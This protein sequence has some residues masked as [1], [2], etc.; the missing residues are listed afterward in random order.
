[1]TIARAREPIRVRVEFGSGCNRDAARLILREI[2]LEHGPSAVDG[3]IHELDLEM[4][5]GLKPGTDF[6]G[7]A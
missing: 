6:D 2:Q 1:M 5:F 4:H 3:L 7:V